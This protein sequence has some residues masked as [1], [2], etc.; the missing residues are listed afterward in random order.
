[1]HALP[2][3]MALRRNIAVYLDKPMT[4]TWA[5]ADLVGREAA[6]RPD[7]VTQVGTFGH[8]FYTMPYCA[9]RI[10]EG[11][12]GDVTDV[13]CYDDR[14]NSMMFRPQPAP[15]PKGMDWDVWCGG[16]PVCD[17]YPTTEDY[18]G[19]HPHDWHSW[20]DYGNGA[21]G[22][23]GTHIMDCAFLALDL[24]KTEPA[25]ID[26]IDAQFACPGAW[27][28][29][30]TIDFHFPA[31]D[32]FGPI[33][34]HWWDGV[35][36]GIPYTKEYVNKWGQLNVRENQN[37]PPVVLELEKKYGCRFWNHG[38]VMVGTKGAMFYSHHGAFRFL[39]DSLGGFR[40]RDHD[41]SYPR[42]TCPHV[43]EFFAAVR[44]GRRANDAFDY[45][46]PLAKTV[47]LGNVAARAGKGTLLWDGRRVTNNEKANEFLDKP[48]REGWSPFV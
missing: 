6:A 21:I 46:V 36:N 22:N 18:N 41:F 45:N 10:K 37:L 28:W 7:V 19:I 23:M 1:H 47:M 5:E 31:H 48:Y 14:L 40:D 34:L 20:I 24:W 42:M 15:P 16:S 39:P 43:A 32:G 9:A 27:A 25:Q 2:A 12:I 30:D 11:A 35:K 44:E 33:K 38:F 4:L 17:Y 26:T 13:W 29:R 8:S 3:V